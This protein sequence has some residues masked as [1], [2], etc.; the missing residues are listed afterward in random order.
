[1]IWALFARPGD[2][3]A[4]V[5]RNLE[6]IC[7]PTRNLSYVKH[8]KLRW[9]GSSCNDSSRWILNKKPCLYY[10]NHFYSGVQIRVVLVSLW[11]KQIRVSLSSRTKGKKEECQEPRQK[12]T[13]SDPHQSLEFVH[14]LC[15]LT[16]HKNERHF[17]SFPICSSIIWNVD[18]LQAS[19]QILNSDCN[20]PWRVADPLDYQTTSD[21]SSRWDQSFEQGINPF[22]A[23]DFRIC[24]DYLKEHICQLS[25]NHCSIQ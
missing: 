1:M 16:N 7:Q 21:E 8:Q 13:R 6:V 19:F 4:Q 11:G 9:I 2:F 15:D 14:F 23:C 10:K 22:F 18:I 12:F 5:S 24:R 20:L 25:E 17:F 3:N